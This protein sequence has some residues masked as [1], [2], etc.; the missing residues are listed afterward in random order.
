MPPLFLGL[1]VG[2]PGSVYSLDQSQIASG[3]GQAKVKLPGDAAFKLH[4]KTGYGTI[5]SQFAVA[6]TKDS[7]QEWI[8]T[9]GANPTAALR[10]ES[11]SGNV[12]IDKR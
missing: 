11:N 8:G 2:T 9:V 3:Y 10:I 1:D 6:K 7:D 4:A 12:E 5:R